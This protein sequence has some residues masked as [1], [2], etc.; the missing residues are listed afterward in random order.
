MKILFVHQNYPGQFRESLPRLSAGGTHQIV[1]LTKRRVDAPQQGHTIAVYRDEHRTDAKVHRMARLF[2]TQVATG[3][4]VRDACADLKKRGFVP[5]VI[6]GH[7]GWGELM[8]I[9]D[10]YPD[11]PMASYFEYYFIP[12]GGCVAYDPEFPEAPHVETLLHA[13]NA[14]NYLTLARSA[15]GFTATDWQKQTYPPLFHPT[16][17]VLHEG[18]RT[19]LLT[20]DHTSDLRV[21]AGGRTFSRDDELVT[22][23]ARNLEPIRGTHTM[24]R[25]LPALQKLRPKAQVAIIGADGVSYGRELAGGETFRQ[26][27]VR[28]L[29]NKVDWSRVHFVGQV[30]Y[31][32]LVSLLR[33]SR[34]HVYLTAPFVISWSMMEA[35]ALEKV[36]IASDN[37]PV[38][39]FIAPGK[40]GLLVDFFNPAQL[41]ETIAR[42][43]DKPSDFAPIGQAA[44]REIVENYDFKT[45]AFPAFERFLEHVATLPS[46]GAPAVS[47]Q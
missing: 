10:V 41:A 14:M 25:S 31:H 35:M 13:R 37:A 44:R 21:E 36:I 12:K 20:P 39:Q 38:R 18:I 42:V 34:A 2:D 29:G 3:A 16:M 1:F 27:F 30:A 28:E 17:H 40:T 19:D 46:P 5:D 22:Y 6:V 45:V 33:L 43:C 11:A 9:K 4:A 15:A 24:L 32:D 26:R 23:I 8:F 7:A 47:S